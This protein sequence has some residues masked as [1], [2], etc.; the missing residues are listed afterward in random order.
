MCAI[1]LLRVS[2]RERINAAA[3]ELLRQLEKRE[4][5]AG[6][7]ELRELLTERLTAELTGLFEGTVAEYEDR[8]RRSEQEIRRQE[9]L[10]DAVLKP[11]VRLTRADATGSVSLSALAPAAG[12]ARRPARTSARRQNKSSKKEG[13]E[14]QQEATE[15]ESLQV[16]TVIDT[17][18]QPAVEPADLNKDDPEID[19]SD[20][21]GLSAYSWPLLGYHRPVSPSS[22]E[23]HDDDWS[24]P[25]PPLR[26]ARK[27]KRGRPSLAKLGAE[28]KRKRPPPSQSF[29][30]YA[31]GRSLQGK[32]F[33]LKHV[34]TVCAS[35]RDSRCGY[36]G[37]LLS[38][39]DGLRAH[40]QTHQ[41]T[42]KT[43][44]F[45]G[46]SFHSILAQELHVRLHTGE[47]PYSCH[48]CGKKFSQKG[49]LTSHL[50][51]HAAEK[52]F[53]CKECSRAFCHATSL[54]R[55]VE[56][57]HAEERP[58]GAAHACGVCGQEFRARQGLRKHMA[59]HRKDGSCEPK[60]CGGGSGPP[61]PL[62]CRV[63]GEAFERKP[64]LVRHAE[65]H[66]KEPGCRCGVCG[67]QYESAEKL[68]AHLN[69]HRD[70]SSTCDTCG[71]SFPGQSA[72]LMHLRIHTGEKPFSCSYCGKA[73]NQSGN[74]KT[75]LKIHTGERAF[76]CSICG[77]GFT[78]KQTLDIHVRF[79]KKER[80]FLCQVCG[81]GFMQDVDLKRHILIH[82]GEKPYGCQVCGKSFQ[83]K[84]SLNGHLKA[85][86][87]GG[88][89]DHEP[90]LDGSTELERMDS[91]YSGYLQ[92]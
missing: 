68:R 5:A 67:H 37:E 34:L 51:V 20:A 49:N 76:S 29:D 45:C 17:N 31:C 10:L 81:K 79:H 73:F 72:L 52:P 1:Q 7:R 55:H 89:E 85:H 3:D 15:K 9:R 48:V 82:T 2:V 86:A 71:K 88:E 27:K 19:T 63:C 53:R 59:S 44:S 66:L 16:V 50:H 30:C 65:A 80:R 23:E 14:K 91:F 41:K 32:G 33:L 13:T 90:E 61:A 38:S 22:I 8:L 58:G 12:G 28:T 25:S 70:A 77:K 6:L 57:H 35:N 83:A 39:A 92:L 43:C 54:E 24:G 64:V 56:E 47:K 26:P 21:S 42:S 4:E 40:L 36:C 46:K 62:P 78:Q 69:S 11:Q 18:L 74:L 87:A 60:G 84:R 75:H